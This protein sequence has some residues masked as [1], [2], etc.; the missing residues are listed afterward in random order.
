MAYLNESDQLNGLFSFLA[1]LAAAKTGAAFAKGEIPIIS[2]LFPPGSTPIQ[3]LQANKQGMPPLYNQPAAL[4]PLPKPIPI[5]PKSPQASGSTIAESVQ[6]IVTAISAGLASIRRGEQ[7]LAT[8][9]GTNL[10]VVTAP[11]KTIATKVSGAPSGAASMSPP[12]DVQTRAM[13]NDVGSGSLVPMMVRP[14]MPSWVIP[15]AL[16]GGAVVLFMVMRRR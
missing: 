16:A 10:P 14:P 8:A 7:P 15:V 11:P 9:I 13:V 12:I 1:P 5:V 3:P 4:P 2:Q 6:G